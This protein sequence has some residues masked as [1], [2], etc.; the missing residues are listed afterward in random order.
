MSLITNKHDI[1]LSV[2]VMLITSDYDYDPRPNS[3]SATTLLKPMRA[4]AL[5]KLCKDKL[6]S[7]IDVT[8]LVASSTGSAVHNQ[9]ENTW[10]NPNKVKSALEKLGYASSEVLVNPEG[11]SQ[12]RAQPN[13]A[14]VFVEKR[15]ELAIKIR[16]IEFILTG[17][18]DMVLQGKLEDLKNTGSFKVSKTLKEEESYQELYDRIT[19]DNEAEM[20]E[21]IKESCP[22]IWEYAMQGSIYRLLNPLIITESFMSIQFI[23]K[24][25]MKG[26]VGQAFYPEINPFQFDIDLFSPEATLAWCTEQLENLINLNMDNLP[27]CTDNE[28]WRDSA[29]VKVYKDTTSKRALPKGTFDTYAEA[30]NFSTKRK[31][32]GDIRVIPS[33]PRRCAYCNVKAVCDQYEKFIIE[34][35]ITEE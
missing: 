1:S 8:D 5:N 14:V 23:I 9:L 3:V 33:V 10:L 12:V 31:V 22:S 4:L 29:K 30:E 28:L 20:I 35:L 24:D 11:L 34:G 17:K 32:P 16:D 21:L 27:L 2:A 26:K 7:E 19:P 25:F 6:V 15:S 13:A 18:F